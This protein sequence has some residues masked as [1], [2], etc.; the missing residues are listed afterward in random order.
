MM[1]SQAS[2]SSYRY[3]APNSILGNAQA[4]SDQYALG[5]I[6]YEW[7]CGNPPFVGSVHE[8]AMQ[9]LQAVPPSLHEKFS[10][11]SYCVEE[12]VMRALA[13]DPRGRFKSVSAFAVAFDQAA[14]KS[15]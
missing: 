5:I 11:I 3:I 9:H 4:A 12:V 13:K 1:N 6:I 10:D 2:I 14:A 7:L 8:V 15:S